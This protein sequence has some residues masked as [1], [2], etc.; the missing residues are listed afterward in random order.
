MILLAPDS[1]AGILQ[2][3]RADS[4]PPGE[5]GLWYV[6][7]R[8]ITPRQ[9]DLQKR[10][11][12]SGTLPDWAPTGRY[13]FLYCLTEATLMQGGEVVMN[14][15]PGEL[16]KHLQFILQA[17]G[18]VLV[19]GLGLGCVV[20]GLLAYGQVEHVDVVERSWDVLKLCGPYVAD[21]RLTVYVMDCL[22]SLPQGTWDYAWHDLWS[23]PL[24]EEPKLSVLHAR[25]MANL[26]ARVRHQGAWAMPRWF[27]RRIKSRGLLT[28][29][30][31]YE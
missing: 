3:M 1:V 12:K 24:K 9:E 14:D 4:I 26:K 21:R 29:E 16:K 10:L 18:R 22:K 19:T 17:Q 25:L 15:F 11:V 28:H 27:C 8:E 31:T 30:V 23:D 13:T 2:S 20:R 5:A 6:A 7:K